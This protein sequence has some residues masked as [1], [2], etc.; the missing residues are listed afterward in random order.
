MEFVHPT[1]QDGLS[2]VM[3][4]YNEE[5]NIEHSITT[6]INLIPQIT[7]LLYEVVVVNDGSMDQTG[8]I[9]DCLASRFPMVTGIHHSHNQGYGQALLTGFQH[10]RYTS[11]FLTDSDLQFD[12]AE[13]KFF[14]KHLRNYDMV[15][16]YRLNRQDSWH[17]LLFAWGWNKLIYLLFGLK[18]KDVDCAFKLFRREVIVPMDIESRGAMVSSEFLIRA[19]ANG[20]LWKEIGVNHYP[21]KAGKATG[22]QLWVIYRAFKEMSRF[23]WKWH[24]LTPKIS[25]YALE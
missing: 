5:S 6:C 4:A 9:L 21:R 16:G 18:I 1:C 12:L 10:S 14:L 17:R 15:I 25:R 23:Y 19:K 24:I 7:S 3:P 11:I 20:V 22:G 13:L 2:I 8:T